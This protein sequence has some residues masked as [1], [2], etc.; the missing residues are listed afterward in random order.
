MKNAHGPTPAGSQRSAEAAQTLHD[1]IRA[2]W[3]KL[4]DFDVG[5]LKDTDDL[6]EHV[7]E[8][9]SLDREQ[10]RDDVDTL[11]DGRSV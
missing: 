7:A 4:S 1:E 2:R 3:S 9:Y 8:L 11:L 5:A 6:V 10:V